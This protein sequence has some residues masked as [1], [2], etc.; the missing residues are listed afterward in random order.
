M[1]DMHKL[2]V[3]VTLTQMTA[4]KG[5]KKHGERAVAAINKEYTK[6][7]DMKVMGGLNP[8]SLTISQKKGALRAINLIKKAEQ[9]TKRGGVRRWTTPEMLH[10]D[11]I[12]IL[13]DHLPG[14]FFHMLHHKCTRRKRCGNFDVPGEYLNADTPEDKFI[15]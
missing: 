1:H 6:L 10:N 3:D 12:R 15:L 9:K 7:E 4:K 13:A 14:R 11:R 2:A 5:I 8:D